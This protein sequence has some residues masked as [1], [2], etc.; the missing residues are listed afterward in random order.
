MKRCVTWL[1]VVLTCV[2]SACG[3]GGKQMDAEQFFKPEMVTVLQHIQQG[4]EK[5]ARAALTDGQ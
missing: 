2:L 3:V 1:G 5:E 4:H